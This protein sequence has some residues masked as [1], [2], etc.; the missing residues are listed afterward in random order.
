MLALF[1]VWYYRSYIIEKFTKSSR[2][3]LNYRILII[4]SKYEEYTINEKTLHIPFA[5]FLFKW[6]IKHIHHILIRVVQGNFNLGWPKIISCYITTTVTTALLLL[7]K[8]LE[9]FIFSV[10]HSCFRS[11]AH[12]WR[13]IGFETIWETR[14]FLEYEDE[15]KTFLSE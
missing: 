10:F 4:I 6:K 12:F 14:Y 13:K 8:M 1:Y 9:C 15:S 3:L 2:M 7:H 11:I 5:Y